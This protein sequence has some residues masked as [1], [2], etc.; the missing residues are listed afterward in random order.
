MRK[1]F[2]K[3]SQFI[4]IYFASSRSKTS[5]APSIGIINPL[6]KREPNAQKRSSRTS[7]PRDFAKLRQVIDES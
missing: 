7:N 1:H 4:A 2:Y 5:F 3:W 6:L